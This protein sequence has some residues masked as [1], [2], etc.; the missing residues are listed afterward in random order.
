[1]GDKPPVP[2]GYNVSFTCS[3]IVSGSLTPM[4]MWTTTASGSTE[5]FTGQQNSNTITGRVKESDA[6]FYTCQASIFA[7]SQCITIKLT[8]AS[9]LH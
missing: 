1:M 3:A 6:G 2:A 9:M 8:V 7:S 5:F 4:F